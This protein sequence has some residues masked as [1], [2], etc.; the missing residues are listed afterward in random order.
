VV[1]APKSVFYYTDS[2]TF[3]GAEEALVM[4]LECVDPSAWQ[5]RLLV[6][7]AGFATRLAERARE[8]GVPVGTLP[9][10]PLGPAGARRVPAVARMLRAQAPTV[11]HAHLSSPLAAKY[12][13]LAALFARIPAVVGTVHLIPD[14][15]IDRSSC[16]QLRALAKGV[17][18][19]IAVSHDIRVTLIDRFRWPADKIEVV[20][21]AVRLEQFQGSASPQLRAQVTAGR[22]G[23][24]V[25]TCA[26]LEPQKGLD[27]LLRAAAE[28][29][30]PVFVI[31][32][33]GSQRTALEA[34]A[35]ALGLGDRVIFA[36]LRHDVPELLGA[37]DAFVLPSLYEGTSLA[38]LE[39]M[40][41]GK[42]I[43]STEIGGTNEL[44]VQGDSGL[45]VPAGDASAL[46]SA[47]RRVLEDEALRA[48]LGARARERAGRHFSPDAKAGRVVG[49]YEHLLAQ[50]RDD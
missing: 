50:R 3:G 1:N 4:L 11:F 23:P 9:P 38:L 7:R 44:I 32:G 30:E 48:A 45:L 47:V 22:R 35:A 41:A 29:P 42:A 34:Q 24:F 31:A 6:D 27:V 10:M 16:L 49:I 39:A 36:G 19:Y 40:A 15:R 26:R 33:E 17:G 37:C 2:R 20:H 43:V 13:M 14:Y 21:N 46:A 12:A 25:L 18:R 5:R 28:L 8:L